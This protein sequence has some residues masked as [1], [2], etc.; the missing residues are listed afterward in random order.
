MG[1]LALEGGIL[2]W[3]AAAGPVGWLLIV[4]SLVSLALIAS[5]TLQIVPAAGGGAARLAAAEAWARGDRAAAEAA[6]AGADRPADR[7]ATGLIADLA[8]GLPAERAAAHAEAR[9]AEALTRLSSQLRSLDVIAL[10]AP[11]LG[12]LGTVIGMISSFQSL[13]A[14]GG[15]ANAAVLAGGIWTALLTT[16]MGLVVAIPAGAA[17]ALLSARV[18]RAAGE[19]EDAARRLLSAEAERAAS[20]GAT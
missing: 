12:L 16:A 5:K 9:G 15:A 17:A 18:E 6:L 1:G 19:I 13:E 4:L 7:V 20:R 11:L 10:S 2:D 8:A 3:A 14:A